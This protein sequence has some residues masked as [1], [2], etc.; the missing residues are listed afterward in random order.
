ML[1]ENAA[2]RTLAEL[3]AESIAFIV[4]AALDIQSDDYSFG[5]VTTWA[6]AATMQLRRSKSLHRESNKTADRILLATESEL[7]SHEAA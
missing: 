7:A 3:E 6:G 1:H 4:C 2:D 5:Y